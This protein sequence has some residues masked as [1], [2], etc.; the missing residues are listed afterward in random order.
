[1]LKKPAKPIVPPFHG[2]FLHV[3]VHMRSATERVAVAVS[4]SRFGTTNGSAAVAMTM[5]VH[6]LGTLS[7]TVHVEGPAVR[8]EAPVHSI[9]LAIGHF[10]STLH[11]VV[12]AMV[13]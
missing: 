1:M 5:H 3:T 13:M 8:T 7:D 12:V 2:A 4:S 9:M 10:K 6:S 11:S